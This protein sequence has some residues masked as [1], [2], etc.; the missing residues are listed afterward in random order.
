MSCSSFPNSKRVAP[1]DIALTVLAEPMVEYGFERLLGIYSR[2]KAKRSAVLDLFSGQSCDSVGPK[3][4]R[5]QPWVGGRKEEVPRVHFVT[6]PLG[7]PHLAVVKTASGNHLFVRFASTPSADGAV[8]IQPSLSEEIAFTVK[9]ARSKGEPIDRII[10]V[11]TDALFCGEHAVYGSPTQAEGYEHAITALASLLRTIAEE[12]LPALWRTR[13]GLSGPIASSIA[14]ALLEANGL[15]SV[16]IG[17]PSLDAGL[18][19]ALEGNFGARPE[20]RLRLAS[21]LTSKGIAVRGAIDPLVP[22]LTDQRANLDPL[23]QALADAGIHRISARYLI[24]T[25]DKAKSL[26]GRLSRMQR[27]LIQGCFADQPWI[28]GERSTMAGFEQKSHKLLPLALREKGHARLIDAAARVGIGSDIL[29]PAQP[30]D[31]HEIAPAPVPAPTKKAVK[32][33]RLKFPQL[34]LFRARR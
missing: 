17:L 1:G 22:M 31:R 32:R 12:R 2:K 15:I 8:A 13:G 16:E 25:R 33:K 29:D 34:D 19:R 23:L 7:S 24:L 5:L 26:S 4:S 3:S 27:A 10:V 11:G 28:A 6:Q 20:E 9:S 21:S 18:C 14:N 30:E